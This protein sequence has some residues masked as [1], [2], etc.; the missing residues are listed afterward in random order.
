MW[1]KPGD[2]LRKEFTTSSPANGQSVSADSLPVAVLA[3]NGTA[4]NDVTV[5]VS[6]IETGRYLTTCTIPSDYAAGDVI[7]LRVT[8]TVSGV[9]GRDTLTE[10]RLQAVDFATGLAAQ[11]FVDGA[12]NKLKVNTD[13]SVEAGFTVTEGNITDLAEGVGAEIVVDIMDAL[14][15]RTIR[16]DSPFAAGGALTVFSGDDY[17]AAN[18]QSI[19]ATI[20]GRTDLIGMTSVLYLESGVTLTATGSVVATGTET[21]TFGDLTAAQTLTL[22]DGIGTAPTNRKYQIKFLTGAGK[23]TT[24]IDGVMHVRRGLST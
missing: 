4:D 19:T 23:V 24:Q 12:A 1:L 2:T 6:L 8:A 3:Q 18:G 11:L 13:H 20:T 17:L 7:S 5:T 9:T 22:W 16:I 21:L 14:T 10:Q 15:G